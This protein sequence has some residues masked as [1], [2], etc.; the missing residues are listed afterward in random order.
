VI[1][2][3]GFYRER[4]V[5]PEVDEGFGSGGRA[6][7]ALALAGVD[8]DWYYYCPPSEQTKPA[9][10]VAHARLRHFP[11]PADQ[12]VSFRYFHPLSKPVFTPARLRTGKTIEARGDVAL[13]FGYLEGD[14]RIEARR[15][16][17]DPQ[18]PEPTAFSAN[19]SKAEELSVVLNAVEAR[20][21]GEADEETVAIKR[22][23]ERD[24]ATVVIV[25]AG[26]D[27]SRVYDADGL[28]GA[29]PAYRT[30]SV[31]KIGSGDVFSAAFSYHWGITGTD[32]LRATDAASRCAARYCASRYP[33]ALLDD[34]TRALVPLARTMP[35]K[36]YIAAPFF[37]MAELWLVEEAWAAFKA[38]GVDVFSPYHDVGP[39]P[40]SKVAQVDLA[41]LRDCTAVLAVL[42]GC[43]PGTL[44][45]VGYAVKHGIPVIGLSQNPKSNDQ[46]MLLGSP[47]CHITDDFATAIY[48]AAW[49]SAR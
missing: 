26:T 13:R 45:E 35:G 33:A 28:K 16:V 27:G 29:V 7:L 34:G 23:L 5:W 20:A 1:V 40:P 30:H 3:G 48:H 49:A 41:A 39:G 8:V 18:S 25:K 31:Y 9:A 19:G 24:R 4:C 36:V 37:T 42:D 32:V 17:Y 6:A 14:C 21:L 10:Q 2:A 11:A 43:D 47:E 12:L 44:F 22:I 46:T 38:L 15:A